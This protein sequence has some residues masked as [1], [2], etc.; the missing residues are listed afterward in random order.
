MGGS[1]VEAFL[2]GAATY[3][4]T[5]TQTFDGPV[6]VAIFP[7]SVMG[8]RRTN[9]WTRHRADFW[10]DFLFWFH[11]VLFPLITPGTARCE[12]AMALGRAAMRLA[13]S[14]SPRFHASFRYC[15]TFS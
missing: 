10:A 9:R 15:F 6:T 1:K 2:S 8:R 3:S 4:L 7:R 11:G 13:S 12:S 14:A 5:A